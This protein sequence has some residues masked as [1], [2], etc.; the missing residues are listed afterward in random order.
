MMLREPRTNSIFSSGVGTA[1]AAE[2]IEACKYARSATPYEGTL[3]TATSSTP[4]SVNW[5]CPWS[6]AI[7]PASSS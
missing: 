1:I 3:T 6:P 2:M 5:A 4:K 7:S